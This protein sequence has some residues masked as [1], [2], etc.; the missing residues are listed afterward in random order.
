LNTAGPQSLTVRDTANPAA[1]GSQTGIHVSPLTTVT[2][3]DAGL[4]NQTVT[5]ALGATSGLPAGTVFTYAVDWNG[6]GV[7]DQ[8]VTGVNGTTVNHS[9]ASGGTYNVGVTATVHIGTEDYTSYTA[10]HAVS[11][12]AVTAAV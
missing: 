7:V 4:R 9:Y 5:F 10:Y 12:F 3:P 1:T 11:I 8:T 6:D 2:G